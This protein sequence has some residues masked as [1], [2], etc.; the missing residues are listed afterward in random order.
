MKVFEIL[1]ERYSASTDTGYYN[2][3]YDDEEKIVKGTVKD[4]MKRLGVT[5]EDL[6]AA[7]KEAQKLESY[8]Q[9]DHLAPDVTNAAEEKNGTFT[10]KKVVKYGSGEPRWHVYSN[11]LIRYSAVSEFGVRKPTRLMSPKPRLVAGKTVES[12]VKIYDGAF[13]ELLAKVKK[14]YKMPA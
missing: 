3:T 5:P 8:K 11:G 12:L 9:L 1:N 13:K 2:K 14:A 4:W 6:K 7:V 10:F